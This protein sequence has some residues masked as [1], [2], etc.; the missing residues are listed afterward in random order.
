MSLLLG[1]DDVV[2]DESATTC[3]LAVVTPVGLRFIDELECFLTLA[4]L[5]HRKFFSLVEREVV[6]EATDWL[7]FTSNQVFKNINK[8]FQ[9][10]L[11]LEAHIPRVIDMEI[12]ILR[13]LF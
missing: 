8:Q 3:P 12:T 13:L 9:I 6:V 7:S 1:L 5:F 2:V 11:K 4:S 10:F